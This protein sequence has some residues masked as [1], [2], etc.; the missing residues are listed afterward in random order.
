MLSQFHPHNVC[1]MLGGR[2]RIVIMRIWR[3]RSNLH[4]TDPGGVTNM[5]TQVGLVSMSPSRRDNTHLSQP[6][7]E[8]SFP[9]NPKSTFIIIQ[10]PSNI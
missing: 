2:P 8:T 3:E 9:I 4:S 6:C 10:L 5:I 7:H 1:V